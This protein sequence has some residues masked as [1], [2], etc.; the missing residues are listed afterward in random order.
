[1]KVKR[2]VNSIYHKE[3]LKQIGSSEKEKEVYYKFILPAMI[4]TLENTTF[5]MKHDVGGQPCYFV[6]TV[7]LKE[8]KFFKSFYNVGLDLE[9]DHLLN[10]IAHNINKYFYTEAGYMSSEKYF[11]PMRA[12]ELISKCL[13][14]G[15]T[16]YVQPLSAIDI[17][18]YNDSNTPIPNAIEYEN[19][20]IK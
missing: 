12:G 1:M 7:D 10:K 17:K 5:E 20:K 3:K 13:K 14:E 4:Y 15:K 9:A 6:R 11:F 19:E 16:A 8:T 2:Y 18:A